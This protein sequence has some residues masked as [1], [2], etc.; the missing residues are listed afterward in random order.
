MYTHISAEFT[1]WCNSYSGKT[2]VAAASMD[3]TVRIW[4]GTGAPAK[5]KDDG[6]A[7]TSSSVDCKY[8]C[9]I[10]LPLERLT[11]HE[12][13]CRQRVMQCPSCRK[14]MTSQVLETHASECAEGEYQCVCSAKV[15]NRDRKRHERDECPAREVE[16]IQG[17]GM[18]MKVASL[19]VHIK[20]FCQERLVKCRMVSAHCVCVCACACA[21]ACVCVRVCACVC[22]CGDRHY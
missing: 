19:D 21:C 13:N 20:S 15:R 14:E 10:R 16:C 11:H 7:G 3:K 9:G 6:N 2:M 8:A 4:N 22:A 1:R 17:C 5:K 12:E 18:M